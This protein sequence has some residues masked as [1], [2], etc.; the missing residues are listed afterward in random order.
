[1][2]K[3]L[4]AGLVAAAVVTISVPVVLQA[5]DLKPIVLQLTPSGA[6]A[7]QQMTI[8][9]SHKVPI[10]IEVKAYRRVQKP[11]GTDVLTLENNDIII[12]PP[13]MVVAPGTSQAFKV[14]WVGDANP[15]S[16]LSYRI[17]TTQLPINF[18]SESK[19][20][21][22]A[23]VSLNYTYEA[24]L[25]IVPKGSAPSASIESAAPVTDE[26]GKTWLE[27]VIKN[28]GNARALLDQP[29]ITLRPG[30]G[31][32]EV[33]LSGQQLVDLQNLNILAGGERK[34]RIAWPEALA[35]S[36]VTASLATQ[37]TTLR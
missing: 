30:A 31:G 32:A 37:Y 33:T 22:S 7:S 19:G 29:R 8:T 3:Y 16:E 23:K 2:T 34:V 1:M 4:T 27:F 17:V 35:P 18:R 12:S 5:Y 9:N 20:D 24:A 21:V 36:A 26:K 6:G 14:R 25:Y 15:T 28:S 10:A 13:Q 11:D